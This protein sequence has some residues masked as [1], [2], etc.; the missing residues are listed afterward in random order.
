MNNPLRTRCI[1]VVGRNKDG[2]PLLIIKGY[3]N[4]V[5][6]GVYLLSIC[7]DIFTSGKFFVLSN[8]NTLFQHFPRHFEKIL[9]NYS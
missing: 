2:E 4:Y 8:N 5:P 1:R 9:N 7:D 3:N 6:D